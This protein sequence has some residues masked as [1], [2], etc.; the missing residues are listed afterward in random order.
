MG[1]V[2]ICPACG[3]DPY[4]MIFYAVVISIIKATV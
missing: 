3:F 1:S 4:D 2:I